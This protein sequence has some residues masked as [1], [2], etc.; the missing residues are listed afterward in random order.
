[1]AIITQGSRACGRVT[2]T[3]IVLS[4][5]PAGAILCTMR[6]IGE[7]LEQLSASYAREVQ[8]YVVG[9][10]G[11]QRAACYGAA[12]GRVQMSIGRDEF[13][14]LHIAGAPQVSAPVE[15]QSQPD[16]PAAR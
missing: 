13:L 14:T 16:R 2:Y 10:G 3:W 15:V 12:H 1:M 9:G 4:L 5:S 7:L 11:G 6:S 8:V